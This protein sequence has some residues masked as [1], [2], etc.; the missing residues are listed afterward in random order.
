MSELGLTNTSTLS[1]SKV[2]KKTDVIR[3]EQLYIKTKYILNTN[4]ETR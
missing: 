3:D 4:R 1:L 2:K